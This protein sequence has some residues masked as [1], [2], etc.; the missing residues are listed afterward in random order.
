MSKGHKGGAA[1]LVEEAWGGKT[2]GLGC[3][4]HYV[5]RLENAAQRECFGPTCGP[6]EG[7]IKQIKE[8][9]NDEK[10][11]SLEQVF[12][13]KTRFLTMT[14]LCG[15]PIF[16]T[17]TGRQRGGHFSSWTRDNIRGKRSSACGHIDICVQIA[18]FR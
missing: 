11:K 8:W 17:S 10:E 12:M 5:E 3:F 4:H 2:P 9:F 15:H 7:H 13:P 16:S 18:L 6:E 1:V 14:S